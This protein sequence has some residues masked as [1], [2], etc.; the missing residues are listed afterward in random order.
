MLALHRT[1]DEV[2]MRAALPTGQLRNVLFPTDPVHHTA[3]I[4]RALQTLFPAQAGQPHGRAARQDRLGVADAG[5]IRARLALRMGQSAPSDHPRPGQRDS[6]APRLRHPEAATW[7]AVG[8]LDFDAGTFALDAMLYDS[9]ICDRFVITGAMAMRDGLE[10]IRWLRARNRWPAPQVR[11]A[12]G[13]PERRP[14]AARAHE[15]RQSEADLPGVLRD[16]VEHGAVRCERSLYAAAYGFS[17]DGDIGFDVLIQLLPFHFLADFRASVQLKRGSSNLFKVSVAGEL[18]GPLP[19]RASG[20]ATFEILWCDFSVSFNATLVDGGTPNDIVLVD[21]LG[22]LVTALQD[23][24][25]WQAQLPTGMDQLVGL[26][27][28]AG[29]EVLLH[30]LGTLSVRQT[31]VPLNLTRDID[32]VGTG[33]PSG[34]RKF[35]VTGTA[36]GT[37]SQGKNGVS[38]LFAPAQY[39]DMRDEDKLAAPSFEAM[40]AGVT[41][42]DAAYTAG[43]GKTSP[44]EYTDIVIGADG[45][46]VLQPDPYRQ[47]GPT[48]L[49]MTFVSAAGASRIRRPVEKR[50]AAP[51]SAAA[52][53]INPAGWVAAAIGGPQP[54]DA[55]LTWAEARG[56]A[57]ERVGVVVIPRSEVVG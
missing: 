56:A 9:K 42:G 41:F 20:K 55:K 44:F 19:L 11:R 17:I 50:F 49:V 45:N 12:A 22:L 29:E 2:A 34:D 8:I 16:H 40:D 23:A 52:P 15:R 48:V 6:A 31:V 25:A 51:V 47:D 35:S 57:V 21:V 4:L 24:K 37:K 28:P 46:P 27:Q 33:T 10:G 43:P 53:S 5:R 1:F 3:E 36:I 30:P 14:T 38:E 32:R 13:I 54:T 7:T 18:E 39:F 26:R